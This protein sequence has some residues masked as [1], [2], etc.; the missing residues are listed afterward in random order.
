[1]ITDIVNMQHGIIIFFC[2]I[3]FGVNPEVINMLINLRGRWIRAVLNLV[4][5]EVVN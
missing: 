5:I 1:M 4:D 3:V 2:L